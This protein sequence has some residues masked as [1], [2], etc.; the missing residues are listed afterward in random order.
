MGRRRERYGIKCKTS[1]DEPS[2][3][4]SLYPVPNRSSFLWAVLP[5]SP[6]LL[7][8]FHGQR[9]ALLGCTAGIK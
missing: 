4:L 2:D 5:F 3:S 7:L 8:L 1:G 6:S 9:E